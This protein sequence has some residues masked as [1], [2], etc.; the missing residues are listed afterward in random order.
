[1]DH[2]TAPAAPEVPPAP[3]VNADGVKIYPT[4][5]LPVKSHM[6]PS[7]VPTAQLSNI[8]IEVIHVL[9]FFALTI[10][11]FISMWKKPNVRR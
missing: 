3:V 8:Q 9:V 6:E 4:S 11:L 1:M 2:K 7:R 5:F 10:F